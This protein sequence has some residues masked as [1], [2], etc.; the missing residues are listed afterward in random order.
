MIVVH[1]FPAQL[2]HNLEQVVNAKFRHY[3]WKKGHTVGCSCAGLLPFD[4][5][6][7]NAEAGGRWLRCMWKRAHGGLP[8]IVG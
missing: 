4:L 2:D 5:V 6:Y 1:P 7:Q 3:M 8:H